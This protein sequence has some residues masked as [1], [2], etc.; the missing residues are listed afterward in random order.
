MID[1]GTV[2]NWISAACLG[3]S[4]F[5]PVNTFTAAFASASM[6][7][8]SGGITNWLAVKMLFDRIPGLVGS[9]VI[10]ARFREIR[11][12]VKELI[13]E[14][15]FNDEHLKQYFAKNLKEVDWG[16][17]LKKGEGGKAVSPITPLVMKQWEKLTSKDV[18]QPIID[19]QIDKLTESP[20][21]GMLMLVGIDKIR[22]AVNQFVTAFV[23]QMQGRV[24]EAAASIQIGDM[25]IELDEDA[26]VG[27]VHKQL[28]EL[29]ESKLE[30]IHA[31][32]VKQMMEDVMRQHLGWLIVWGNV[33][34]ALIG[35]GAFCLTRWTGASSD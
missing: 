29:L 30:Q 10:P 13:L 23:A 22:P 34:G 16:K 6:F 25:Q 7:A 28:E 21:G 2:S 18:V 9:G 1:K 27:E 3:L 26:V 15:F 5:L 20:I 31:R 35:V 24:E 17:F 12:T 14:H 4:V 11:R 33:F 32:D 8:F 19:Q